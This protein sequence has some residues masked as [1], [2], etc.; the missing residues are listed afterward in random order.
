MDVRR[1]PG[2]SFNLYTRITTN[3]RYGFQS[4]R[5]FFLL[6]S[7]ATR[8]NGFRKQ[9]FQFVSNSA[10]KTNHNSATKRTVTKRA[11]TRRDVAEL[12]AGICES[13]NE[14]EAPRLRQPNAPSPSGRAGSREGHQESRDYGHRVRRH[15]VEGCV[16]GYKE[17]HH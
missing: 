15:R 1:C 11:V 4:R 7:C 16:R 5:Y 12:T 17:I 2:A 14:Q 10:H 13:E 8:A 9:E 6:L 3:S